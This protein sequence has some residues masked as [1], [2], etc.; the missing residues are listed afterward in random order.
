V[1]IILWALVLAA[2]W[3]VALV[4]IARSIGLHSAPGMWTGAFGLPGVVIANWTQ[5]RLIGRFNPYLGYSLMFLI[6]WVFYCTVL[7]GIVSLKRG[8]LKEPAL[9]PKRRGLS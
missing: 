4:I 8:L 5:A 3:T 2:A 1:K 9:Q 6:N 7:Q